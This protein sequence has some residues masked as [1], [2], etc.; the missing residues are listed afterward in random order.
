[1]KLKMKTLLTLIKLFIITLSF[2]YSHSTFAST[3]E[4]TLSEII[5]SSPRFNVSLRD[6][7]QQIE[8]IEADEIKSFGANSIDEALK[9]T[10]IVDVIQRGPF[11]I[12]SDI[13]IRGSTFEQVLFLVNGMRVNDPQT[14]HFH[15]D[16][17]INIDDIERIEI[18]PGGASAIYGHGGFGGTV[19]II[20]KDRVDKNLSGSFKIGANNYQGKYLTLATTKNSPTQI[21]FSY[22]GQKSDGYRLNT[23][24]D[25]QAFNTFINNKNW[26]VLAGYGEKKFGANSFY[27]PKY[28]LQWENTKTFLLSGKATINIDDIKVSPSILSRPH[29]AYY[30]LNRNNPLFYNNKHKTNYYSLTVPFYLEGFD[31]KYAGGI[32]LSHDNINSTRLGNDSRNY[33]ALF[34]SLN[35]EFGR[36][37]TN[38]DIR[39]DHY[40]KSVD[41][42]LSPAF[43]SLYWITSDMKIR[44]ALN[45]S[46]RLPSY[47]ELYYTSP[48]H[49]SNPNLK[50]EKAWQVESGLDLYKNNL[51]ASVTVFKRWGR[52][53]IDW[54]KTEDYW[55]SDN[56]NKV[57]TIGFTGSITLFNK[58]NSIKF[59]YSWLNQDNNATLP[60]NYLNYLRHKLNLTINYSLPFDIK[61]SLMISHMKRIYQPS[62]T[63]IDM[64]LSK[65]LNV[66]KVQTNLFFEAKNLGNKGYYDISSVPMPGRWLFAGLEVKI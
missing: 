33:Q 16:I 36:L 3:N 19:N 65:I 11:G 5:V 39:L 18:M 30:L 53:I 1:M 13:S 47:T 64:R 63:L 35:K 42:E 24:F 50:P 31:T 4:T 51:I 12:Q 49:L 57:D 45:K 2:V 55:I 59:D 52:D 62:Y 7:Y 22:G 15:S 27:T 34:L 21:R 25:N 41:Y 29:Y 32:E 61:S 14:G 23:D 17:S 60:S 54:L 8:V 6:M 66:E 38:L 9:Y 58:T 26:Q 40:D 46:F 56:I 48:S 43:S 20:T 10:S 37:K 44:L 28:P